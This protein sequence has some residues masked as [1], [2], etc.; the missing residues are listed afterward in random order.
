MSAEGIPGSAYNA[1]QNLEIATHASVV[2]IQPFRERRDG[3]NASTEQMWQRLSVEQGTPIASNEF[4]HRSFVTIASTPHTLAAVPAG[5]MADNLDRYFGKRPPTLEDRY[6]A[7]AHLVVWYGN[8]IDGEVLDMRRAATLHSTERQELYELIAAQTARSVASLQGAVPSIDIWGTT[9]FGLPHEREQSGRSAGGP[10]NPLGHHHVTSFEGLHNAAV[11]NEPLSLHEQIKMNAV[12]NALTHK[13]FS[14]PFARAAQH[15]LSTVHTPASRAVVTPHNKEQ[16]RDNGYGVEFAESVRFQDMFDALVTL[17][18]RFNVFY[19]NISGMHGFYHKQKSKRDTAQLAPTT[20]ALIGDLAQELSFTPDEAVD[21]ASFICSIPLTLSQ[22][23]Q[24]L[25][26]ESESAARL[27]HGYRK[28]LRNSIKTMGVTTLLSQLMLDTTARI[29][30]TNPN[31]YAEPSS[32]WPEHFSF[33]W[34]VRD[35]Q[36]RRDGSVYVSALDLYPALGT[37]KGGIE[38][39]T[40]LVARRG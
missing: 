21:F 4:G 5:T 9:G 23:G 12:W 18:D 2:T 36:T 10:S 34:V 17:Y 40:G 11:H 32:V 35:F 20:Q 25:A 27:L 8:K 6:E 3:G 30:K 28:Y 22:R 33:A 31:T 14:T 13:Y 7:P 1:I 16:A 26:S 24:Q 19:Q 29:N 38:N 37:T 39:V 15:T